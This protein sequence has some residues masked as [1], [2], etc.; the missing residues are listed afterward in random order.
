ML[1]NE[2]TNTNSQA[3]LH[4]AAFD[5]HNFQ[6][7][8]YDQQAKYEIREF[9]IRENICNLDRICDV[10]KIHSIVFTMDKNMTIEEFKLITKDTM[11]HLLSVQQIL[12]SYDIT[13]LSQFNFEKCE[14]KFIIKIP[15]FL[16]LKLFLIIFANNEKLQI[17]LSNNVCDVSI[18]VEC[19]FVSDKERKR[20]T[21][22]N[23]DIIYGNEFELG[24]K[25]NKDTIVVKYKAPTIYTFQRC[26]SLTYDVDDYEV[27]LCLDFKN[28]CTKGYFI[29]CNVNDII[30]YRFEIFK[31]QDVAYD[32]FQIHMFCTKI[33]DNL[34][35]VPF[36]INM[37]YDDLNLSSYHGSMNNQSI[38]RTNIFL[39]FNN[40][41]NRVIK[42]HSLTFCNYIM[43]NN[44]M[45]KHMLY[46]DNGY[47]CYGIE[48]RPIKLIEQIHKN[49]NK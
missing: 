7:E 48:H 5:I 33:S 20:L 40:N 17:Q 28:M 47:S 45:K 22:T 38:G 11:I 12:F 32:K 35:Y 37:K 34:L 30:S 39:K 46:S 23:D 31:K 6:Y 26:D 49:V 8:H 25:P 24:M 27:N 14:N 19:I 16:N 3:M 29:E 2:S 10:M 13:F 15:E 44:Y 41:I 43:V 42:I 18:F 1:T 4:L 36:N 21:D 9:Y